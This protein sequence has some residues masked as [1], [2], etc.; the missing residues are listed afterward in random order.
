MYKLE[1]QA[2]LDTDKY[3]PNDYVGDGFEFLMETF[4]KS[5]AFDNRIGIK[6]AL[7]LVCENGEIDIKNR[8]MDNL[9]LELR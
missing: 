8:R 2:Q 6:Q 3:S 7:C 5:H 9:F 1:K 4:I